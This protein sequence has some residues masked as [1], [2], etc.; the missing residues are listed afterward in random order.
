M[1]RSR[2]LSPSTGRFLTKDIWPPDYSRPSSLNDWMYSFSNPVNYTDPSGYSPW[3]CD[4]GPCPGAGEP[5]GQPGYSISFSTDANV[6]WSAKDQT[7]IVGGVTRV[8]FALTKIVEDRLEFEASPQYVWW[9]AMGNVNFHASSTKTSNDKNGDG[10]VDSSEYYFCQYWA[11]EYNIARGVICYDESRD[12]LTPRLVAHELG[13]YFNATTVN[14][15][16]GNPYSELKEEGIYALVQDR[17]GNYVI[18]TIA[19][20]DISRNSGYLRTGRGVSFRQ[21]TLEAEGEDFADTF[22]NWVELLNGSNGLTDNAHGFARQNWMENH[23]ENWLSGLLGIPKPP[24]P[25][26]N[27]CRTRKMY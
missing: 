15:G 1:L 26:F 11:G 24:D 27:P 25:R 13:H 18:E 5:A 12:K 17:R 10:I 19:G 9:K 20:K 4:N 23:M 21:N 16:A 22:A 7:A 8:A 6:S 2:W 3:L 14:R